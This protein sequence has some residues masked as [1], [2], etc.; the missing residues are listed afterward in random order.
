MV[1]LCIIFVKQIC[2]HKKDTPPCQKQ[3]GHVLP[4]PV[5]GFLQKKRKKRYRP[6]WPRRYTKKQEKRLRLPVTSLQPDQ[7]ARVIRRPELVQ[8]VDPFADTHIINR[9]R[10]FTGNRRHHAAFRRSVQLGNHQS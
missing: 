1:P 7:V 4:A 6:A 10:I 8:I 3:G 9:S 5:Y 2:R